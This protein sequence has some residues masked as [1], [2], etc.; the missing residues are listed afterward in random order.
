MVRVC[1]YFV[2][3]IFYYGLYC[4][5]IVVDLIDMESCILLQYYVVDNIFIYGQKVIEYFKKIDVVMIMFSLDLYKCIILVVWY[6]LVV[7]LYNNFFFQE[8]EI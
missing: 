1:L 2:V 3:K 4:V 6:S 8:N 5:L 7:E